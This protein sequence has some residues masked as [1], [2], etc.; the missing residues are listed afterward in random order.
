[1]PALTFL[2]DSLHE[3]LAPDM[4]I[5]HNAVLYSF[6]VTVT[7]TVTVPVGVEPEYYKETVTNA[8]LGVTS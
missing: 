7:V 1:M 6:T 3:L 2:A 8:R 5:T 4:V